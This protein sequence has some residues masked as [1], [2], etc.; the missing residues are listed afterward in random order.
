MEATDNKKTPYS[1]FEKDFVA[2]KTAKD[3]FLQKHG[4][5]IAGFRTYKIITEDMHQIELETITDG[6][7]QNELYDMKS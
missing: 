7:L 4:R 6:G 2:F 3:N 5:V 1:E